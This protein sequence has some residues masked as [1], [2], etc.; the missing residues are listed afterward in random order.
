MDAVT[1]PDTNV[2]EFINNNAVALRVP[3]DS[4]PLA[5]QFN[6]KWT[7]VLAVLDKDGI[8]HQ[9][10]LGFFPPA[11]FVPSLMLGIAKVHFDHDQMEAALAML[12][13][14]QADYPASTVVPESVYLE[15]VCRYKHSHEPKT[16][17]DAYEQLQADFP[18]SEW[19]RRAS[20]YRLL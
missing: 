2:I 18:A 12:H 17:K 4:Q 1:Y 9:Q 7:P 14:L 15:G 3:S 13:K 16:L 8:G 19:T 11:E 10:T 20:P 5:G 6:V